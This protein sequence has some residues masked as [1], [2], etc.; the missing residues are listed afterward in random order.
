MQTCNVDS[1][2]ECRQGAKSVEEYVS[3]FRRLSLACPTM[4]EYVLSVHFMRGLAPNIQGEAFRA[5]PQTLTA[6]ILA[7]R[8]AELAARRTAKRSP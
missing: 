7:A 1:L 8:Q 6:A 2:L 4:P 3:T 5:N